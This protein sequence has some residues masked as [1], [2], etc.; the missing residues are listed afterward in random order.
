MGLEIWRVLGKA[1]YKRSG[2]L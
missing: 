1:D 2:L